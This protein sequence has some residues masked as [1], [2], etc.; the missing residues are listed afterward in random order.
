MSL[1]LLFS[2]TGLFT[3]D[4]SGLYNHEPLLLSSY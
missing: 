2:N 3:P 4:Y 1:L